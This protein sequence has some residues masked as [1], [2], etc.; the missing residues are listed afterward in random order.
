MCPAVSI[1]A[2]ALFG[3]LTNPDI[4]FNTE[5]N[6]ATSG[7]FGPNQV[8]SMLGLGALSLLFFL[9]DR[10]MRCGSLLLRLRSSCSGD[11]PS[12]RAWISSLTAR[13]RHASR[14]RT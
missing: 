14:K 1:A 4:T 9:G 5:S 12:G 3:I 7:G 8:S 10:R 13:S 2:L 6:F 11:M